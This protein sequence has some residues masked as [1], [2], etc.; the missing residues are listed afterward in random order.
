MLVSLV[1]ATKD[2]IA[3]LSRFLD[4]VASQTHPS[5]EVIVVDQNQ[6]ER[7][8][9]AL[10]AFTKCSLKHLK[11]QPGVSRARNMGISVA[12]GD[13]IAFPDDDCWY[14]P[15]LLE[16]VI[17]YFADQPAWAGVCGRTLGEHKTRPLW[18]WQSTEGHLT[19]RN[20]W[21]RVTSTSLFMRRG[22]FEGGLRFDERL[23]LGAGTAWGS[24]EDVDLIASALRA[25]HQIQFVPELVVYHRNVFPV[26]DPAE[27]VKAYRYS[28]GAGFVL[29]K[30]KYPL[31]F[32]VS[33]ILGPLA[34]ILLALAPG[35]LHEGRF[36]AAVARGR[37]RGLLSST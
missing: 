28:C 3:E 21:R 1:I 9:P 19:M 10:G 20:L 18:M 12:G 31:D 6:D 37:L 5:L 23:G 16:R 34:Y 2:R 11:S 7:L 32:V 27:I 13:I 25:G 24:A 8:K 29:R 17:G 33:R 30:H 15:D 36:R 26:S 14:G 35:N 22:V 4:S